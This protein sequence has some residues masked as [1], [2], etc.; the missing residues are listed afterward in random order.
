MREDIH[1]VIS[2]FL[3]SFCERIMR[4]LHH[5]G[6]AVVPLIC[7]RVFWVAILAAGV[8]MALAALEALVE[9]RT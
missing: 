3:P 7:E 6:I 8:F 5:M 1:N 9:V 2:R 4:D